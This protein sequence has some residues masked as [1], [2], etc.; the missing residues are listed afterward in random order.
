MRHS[1]LVTIVGLGIAAASVALAEQ[2]RAVGERQVRR[3]LRQ[4]FPL[5]PPDWQSRLTPD[6]TM[7]ICAQWHNQPPKEIAS[8]FKSHE[9][10]RIR[11]PSDGQ[12]MG[13][14]R[15][16]EALAQSGYGMRFTDTDPARP[17]GGNCYACH[18]LSPEEVSFGTV[19]VSLKGYGRIHKFRPE[20]ARAV[21]EKIYNSQAVV[22]CSLMPR[23][24]ANGILTIEQIKDLVALLMDPE[25]PVNREV[26][27][28]ARGTDQEKRSAGDGKEPTRP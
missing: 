15:R 11:Y 3:V 18:E 13:D 23:F 12:F 10:A 5:A 1:M 26:A 7:A 16:G 9:A 21:Y 2:N 17:N 4:A 25:S 28:P 24:G 22:P 6:S 19:G 27:A 8:D 20:Y 14:W